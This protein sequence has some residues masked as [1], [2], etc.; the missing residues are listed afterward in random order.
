MA[1]CGSAAPLVGPWPRTASNRGAAPP[2]PRGP[3]AQ[4]PNQGA[5]PWMKHAIPCNPWTAREEAPATAGSD[6][7]QCRS[8]ANAWVARNKAAPGTR[9]LAAW[10]QR[11]WRWRHMAPRSA[12]RACTLRHTG[13]GCSLVCTRAPRRAARGVTRGRAANS[14]TPYLLQLRAVG[15]GPRLHQAR[16]DRCVPRACRDEKRRGVARGLRRGRVLEPVQV[17]RAAGAR[18]GTGRPGSRWGQA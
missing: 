6:S 17:G 14:T 5:P 2:R 18:L 7:C 4:Q 8:A 13:R 1:G 15:I 11:T 12:H 3:P 10:R 16:D 9:C